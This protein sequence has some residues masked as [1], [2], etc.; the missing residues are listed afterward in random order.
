MVRFLP[1]VHRAHRLFLGLVICLAAYLVT[2]PLIFGAASDATG[3]IVRWFGANVVFVVLP[4]CA[5]ALGGALFPLA[6]R[7]LLTD[8]LATGRVGGVVYGLDLAGSCIGALVTGAILI[9]VIGFTQTCLVVACLNALVALM[10]VVCRYAS[11]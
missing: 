4:A 10:L 11:R 6:G 5:G 2:L 3:P 7:L 1:I 8:N 9:P